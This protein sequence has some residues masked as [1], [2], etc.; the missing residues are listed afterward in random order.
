MDEEAPLW[1]LQSL[2][3]RC[4]GAGAVDTC[5]TLHTDFHHGYTV[6]THTT[7]DEGSL[8]LTSSALVFCFLDNSQDVLICIS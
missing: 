4:L 2:L 7:V 1:L 3:G 8:F 6:H 5:E